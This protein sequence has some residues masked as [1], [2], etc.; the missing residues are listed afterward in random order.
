MTTGGWVGDLEKQAAVE[1]INFIYDSRGLCVERL[2]RR[3]TLAKEY[4]R[5]TEASSEHF[6]PRKSKRIYKDLRR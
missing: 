6:E 3:R 5:G 4:S 2:D 1:V